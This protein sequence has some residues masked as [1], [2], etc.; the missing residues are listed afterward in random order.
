MKKYKLEDSCLFKITT[1]RKLCEILLISHD[2]LKLLQTNNDL[3][4]SQTISDKKGKKRDCDMPK[5]PLLQKVHKRVHKLLSSIIVPDY[6]FSVKGKNAKLNAKYHQEN[7]NKTII[8]MD[9]KGF[10][11]SI[12]S[13]KVYNL[14]HQVFQC[15]KDIAFILTHLLTHNNCVPTGCHHSSILSYFACK[16]IFDNINKKAISNNCKFSLYVDDITISGN[17]SNIVKTYVSKVMSTNKLSLSEEKTKIYKP[18]YPRKKITGVILYVNGK[19]KPQN[20]TYK[21]IHELKTLDRDDKQSAQLQ[22]LKLEV[23]AI[24]KL[25]LCSSFLLFTAPSHN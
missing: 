12:T 17:K 20:K 10:F 3:F 7:C 1:K 21:K 23:K 16:D 6:I 18:S 22:G 24:K 8:T 5:L 11:P 19:I 13:S 4:R 9:I 2:Q 14:F 15:N 25:N